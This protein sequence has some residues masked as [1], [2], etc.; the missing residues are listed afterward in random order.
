V[1][2]NA[3]RLLTEIGVEVEAER[4]RAVWE[5]VEGSFFRFR[6]VSGGRVVID[7]ETTLRE[8][9]LRVFSAALTDRAATPPVELRV[10]E[11]LDRAY[12][13]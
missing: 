10:Y 13:R 9:T 2:W 8:D 6:V 4:G 7:R 12:G 11:L 1:S 3:S 5:N